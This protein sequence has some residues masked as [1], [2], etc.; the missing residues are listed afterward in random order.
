[1]SRQSFCVQNRPN[2]LLDVIIFGAELTFQ[3]T[4]LQFSHGDHM[5]GLNFKVV[6]DH[7]GLTR[8]KRDIIKSLKRKDN[9]TTMFRKE[10]ENEDRNN[11]NDHNENRGA[12]TGL[13]PDIQNYSVVTWS[14]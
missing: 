13:V 6:Y 9:M 12:E 11:P 14:H 7:G 10:K 5:S 3:V 1:M 4:T 2:L 8:H